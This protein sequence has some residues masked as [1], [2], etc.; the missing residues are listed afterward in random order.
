MGAGETLWSKEG[1][2][3]LVSKK[4]LKILGLKIV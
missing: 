2:G 1:V 3:D 4:F